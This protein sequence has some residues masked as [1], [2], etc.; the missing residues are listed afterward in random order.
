MNLKC[1]F[2]QNIDGVFRNLTKLFW[3][4]SEKFKYMSY[5][6]EYTLKKYS[7]ERHMHN[8]INHGV[9]YS[10]KIWK[11]LICVNRLWTIHTKEKSCH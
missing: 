3:I 2:N 11:Y 7:D 4:S 9:V 5:F 8:D 10:S 6:Q 1:N